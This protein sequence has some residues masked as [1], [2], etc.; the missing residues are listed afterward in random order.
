MASQMKRAD[1]LPDLILHFVCGGAALPDGNDL[2]PELMGLARAWRS[3]DAGASLE[4]ALPVFDALDAHR[5][6]LLRAKDFP[7]DPSIKGVS[8]PSMTQL[9]QCAV[10]QASVALVM[11]LSAWL[12]ERGDV[13]AIRVPGLVGAVYPEWAELFPA[14]PFGESY[15]GPHFLPQ[16]ARAAVLASLLVADDLSPGA[17]RRLGGALASRVDPGFLDWM[18]PIMLPK[19]SEPGADPRSGAVATIHAIISQRGA[20]LGMIDD[21]AERRIAAAAHGSVFEDAWL[22]RK[23]GPFADAA[24][25]RAVRGMSAGRRMEVAARVE[26]LARS[27]RDPDYRGKLIEF[28]ARARGDSSQC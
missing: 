17:V 24:F 25:D 20:G 2:A 7:S 21:P 5:A 27:Q 8:S 13:L 11:A 4:K 18:V 3:G 22:G 26:V 9:T 6:V 28:A 23:G 16:P 19:P 12:L 1:G 15:S 14:G 10:A